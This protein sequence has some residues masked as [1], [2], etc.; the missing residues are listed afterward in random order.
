MYRNSIANRQPTH[1]EPIPPQDASSDPQADAPAR[2]A[3][4]KP[5]VYTRRQVSWTKCVIDREHQS[6]SVK[7]KVLKYPKFK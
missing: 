2:Q 3:N 4:T 6:R 7:L 5:Q 1:F